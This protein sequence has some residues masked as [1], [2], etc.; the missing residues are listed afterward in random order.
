MS[1]YRREDEGMRGRKVE[2]LG[3]T[4]CGLGEVSCV[5]TAFILRVA[6]CRLRI[7]VA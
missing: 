3:A 5:R 7:A 2:R 1:G 4:R 6:A